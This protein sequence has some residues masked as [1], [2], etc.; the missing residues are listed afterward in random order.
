MDGTIQYES[1]KNKGTTVSIFIPLKKGTVIEY[2]QASNYSAL[3]ISGINER[4]QT[5]TI[6]SSMGIHTYD[7]NE[8]T[9]QKVDMIIFESSDVSD[10]MVHKYLE[11]YGKEDAISILCS[12]RND[13]SKKSIDI[14]VD[15]PISRH[16]LFQR[17]INRIGQSKQIDDEYKQFLNAY[18]L[19]VDDNRLNRV[20]FA[21]MLKKLGVNSQSVDS[22]AKAIEAVKVDHFDLILM[23]IHMPG[24]DGLEATRRIR[25][26]GKKE[27]AIPIIAVTANAFLKDYDTMKTSQ[28][29]DI[30]FKPIQVDHLNQIMRKYIKPKN[31]IDIPDDLFVFDQVDFEMRFEGSEDIAVEVIETFYEEYQKDLAKIKSAIQHQDANEI[32]ETTHYFKGSCSYLSAGRIVWILMQLMHYAKINE[33]SWMTSLYDMLEVEVTLLIEQL[34]EFQK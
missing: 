12:Y 3:I 23:D 32:Y 18:V 5:R 21:S 25:S 14:F 24:M 22:G 1:I 15:L 19:I 28:I 16:L 27:Q 4:V 8:I 9:A 29:T 33:M 17:I 7:E 26:L 13:K 34:K 10:Q 6:F 2:P 11:K 30:I 20:A 31:A